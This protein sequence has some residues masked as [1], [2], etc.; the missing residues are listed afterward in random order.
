MFLVFP[1][2]YEEYFI[3]F[4]KQLVEEFLWENIAWTLTEVS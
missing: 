3:L 1:Q 4:S 2:K